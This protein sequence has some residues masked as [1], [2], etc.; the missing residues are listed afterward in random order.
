MALVR[1]GSKNVHSVEDGD[2]AVEVPDVGL[3]MRVSLRRLVRV[4][5]LHVH[6]VGRLGL[7]AAPVLEDAERGGQAHGD[8]VR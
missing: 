2:A 5:R 6:P 4:V 7:M 8:E 3:A 1:L